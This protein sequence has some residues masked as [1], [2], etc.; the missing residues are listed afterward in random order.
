[1]SLL[2]ELRNK[3][4]LPATPATPTAS[5]AIPAAVPATPPATPATPTAKS[6][7]SSKCSSRNDGLKSPACQVSS[8]CSRC[9]RVP[10]LLV[11]IDAAITSWLDHIGETDDAIRKGGLLAC[12]RDPELRAYLLAR[13]EEVPPTD[14]VRVL[15]DLR[16]MPERARAIEVIDADADV[17][18][19]IVA[20]RDIGVCE[21]LVARDRW[22]PFQFLALLAKRT[23][24][25][26]TD[27]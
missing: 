13:A 6:S 24:R 12:R 26:V 27:A 20:I 21:L 5:R 23:E 9:S 2:D 22:D 11:D 16:A 25:E 7:K 15:Q 14:H 8:N 1:M 19:I 17:V 10:T 4:G 3:V 18:R